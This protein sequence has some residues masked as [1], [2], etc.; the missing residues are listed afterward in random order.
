[1]AEAQGVLSNSSKD[2]A[3]ICTKARTGMP[4][5]PTTARHGLRH[6]IVVVFGPWRGEGQRFAVLTTRSH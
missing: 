4:Q 5:R 2:D 3:A 1:M 6:Y